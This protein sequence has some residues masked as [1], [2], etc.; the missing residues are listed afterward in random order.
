MLPARVRWL[1]AQPDAIQALACG[2]P[3]VR[4]PRTRVLNALLSAA[5][6]PWLARLVAC[7]MRE[8]PVADGDDVLNADSAQH[9]GKGAQTCSSASA[10][11]VKRILLTNY[12]PSVALLC[13]F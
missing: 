12:L 11:C 13:G 7:V 10:P 5:G 4:G 6:W 2:M 9:D 1:D 3:I 8:F